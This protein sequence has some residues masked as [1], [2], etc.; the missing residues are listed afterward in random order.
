MEYITE[1]ISTPVK[2]YYDVIVVGCGPAGCGMAIA[3]G[4]AGLKTL[5]IEKANC[6]GGAWTTGF[7]NP[8][9]DGVGKA[10]LVGELIGELQ[11]RGQWGGFWNISFHY[12]HMKHIL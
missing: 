12:E 11:D 8:F 5:V 2:G 4:R 1:T 6:H 7:M 9:F 10:G 3:C